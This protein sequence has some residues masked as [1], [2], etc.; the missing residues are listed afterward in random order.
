[1][2]KTQDDPRIPVLVVT[3]AVSFYGILK[4]EIKTWR[5]YKLLKLGAE[6]RHLTDS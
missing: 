5:S 6:G 3:A 1:M 2:G 4:S